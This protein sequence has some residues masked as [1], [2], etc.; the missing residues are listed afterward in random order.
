MGEKEVNRFSS[1]SCLVVDRFVIH[2][3]LLEALELVQTLLGERQV[4][5]EDV[6]GERR[7]VPRRVVG[8]SVEH[9]VVVV[10]ES[11]L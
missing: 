11:V 9:R 4:L 7:R 1:A 10:H 8:H 2:Q 3:F 5:D 6:E